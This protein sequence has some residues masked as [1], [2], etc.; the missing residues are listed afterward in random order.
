A[1]GL[2]AKF[3]R[4]G[5]AIEAGSVGVHM[6]LQAIGSEASSLAVAEAAPSAR[7]NR[8]SYARGQVSEWYRNGPLG[9]EQGFAIPRVPAGAQSGALTLTMALSGNARAA[10][11]GD[12]RSIVFSHGSTSLSYGALTATD[13]SGRTLHSWLAVTPGRLSLHVNAAGA[14]Y[15]LTIDPLIQK[16]GKLSGGEAEGRFG[17]SEALS[18]DGSTLLVGA[19]EANASRGAV[20]VFVRSGSGP[21]SEWKPQGEMP[22]TAPATV[23]EATG[24]ECVEESAEEAGECAFGS[25]VA[26]SADGNTALIGDPSPT[27]T[28]GTAWIF[29]RSGSQW[30]RGPAL[31]GTGEGNEGR[32]GKSV[33]LSGDGSLALVGVPSANSGR[34]GVWVFTRSESGWTRSLA[35]LLDSEESQLGHF[36][37]SVALSGD[38]STA[39]VGGPGDSRFA[40][41]AWTFTRSGTAWS[42][43]GGK[44]TGD[45]ES[46]EGRHF[47]KTV[48]LSGD[49]ATAL[50]GAQ[51]DGEERGAVWTF[52]RS[53]SVLGQLG[54]KLAGPE[55]GEGRFGASLALSADGSEALI[56]APHTRAGLGSAT[57]FTRSGS[58]WSQRAS[59]GGTEAVGKG[60]RGVSVAISGDGEVAAIGASRDSKRTGAAWVFTK[61]AAAGP[62]TVANVVPGR[63][64]TEGGTPVTITGSNFP[65]AEEAEEAPPI[66]MFGSVQATNVEVATAA[67]IRAVT[68]AE[69]AGLVRVSVRTASGL[70]ES[71]GATFRF[72]AP[73]KPHGKEPTEPSGSS[74]SSSKTSSTST[75]PAAGGVLASAETAGAA[76]LVSLRSKRVAVA[77]HTSAAIRLLRTGAGQCR[78]TVTLRY[79]QKAKGEHYKLKSIGSA[80]FSIA[81]GKS[82]VVRI[83]LN[84]LGRALLI[85]GHGKLNASLA[86]LRTTPGPKLA[87]AAS[88]RLSVKK[89]RKVATVAH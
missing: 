42:Q 60:W 5:V 87:R 64:T 71:D 18:A 53:G 41:A 65:D 39:L 13:A 73:T 61:Q 57:R 46:P 75:S 8:V 79:R 21:G 6:S 37:R 31:S 28:A 86:V 23:K 2:T 14:R 68:P 63:G 59:L 35:A 10:L 83:K 80:H 56:G 66:V 40:G 77:L 29:T 12:G 30:T 20:W 22:L 24:E 49:G 78:G 27:S 50:I 67:E 34:G 76:C 69:P 45:G 25:S 19:P 62:P 43:Q 7:A 48:A 9:V 58:T 81:P 4:G 11:S 84:K 32:F 82:Q 72:E 44:L 1:R 88:V 33:A 85:A 52:S 3:D 38:G 16:G 47:G 15:P 36:G 54:A 51:D 74:Q 17:A 26:L 70:A 55:A 89:T